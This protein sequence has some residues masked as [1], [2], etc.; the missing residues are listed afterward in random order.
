MG[1]EGG[2]IYS[3]FVGGG[4]VLIVCLREICW[5]SHNGDCSQTTEE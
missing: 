4:N 2:T 5:G 3:P 1:G